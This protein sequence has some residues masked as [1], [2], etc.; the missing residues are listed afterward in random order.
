MAQVVECKV[1]SL[2]PSSKKTPINKNKWTIKT[3]TWTVKSMEVKKKRDY[4]FNN[5]EIWTND[6]LKIQWPINIQEEFNIINEWK[7]ENEI[8][9]TS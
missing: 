9:K 6:L 7:Y 3:P 2:I 8:T 1:L 4:S 5:S